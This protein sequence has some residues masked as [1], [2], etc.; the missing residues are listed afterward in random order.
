MTQIKSSN[1]AIIATAV[2]FGVSVA[3]AATSAQAQSN[4]QNAGQKIAAKGTVSQF[5]LPPKAP[6]AKPEPN[7]FEVKSVRPK[8]PR[9]A[10]RKI[11]VEANT[12][13]RT[14]RPRPQFSLPPETPQFADNSAVDTPI[15]E[16]APRPAPKVEKNVE[17]PAAPR[18]KQKADEQDLIEMRRAHALIRYK[19]YLKKYRALSRQHNAHYAA[20]KPAYGH[21]GKSYAH[22][23]YRTYSY[24]PRYVYKDYGHRSYRKYYRGHNYGYRRYNHGYRNY[25][26]SYRNHGYS[27]NRYNRHSYSRY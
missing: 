19:H 17:K 4:G 3:L 2:T 24:A 5:S 23:Q 27:Y 18:S 15:E 7:R 26:H 25:S 9:P 8:S 11:I 6:R 12:N 1:F 22:G 21:Y 10:N 20:K 13:P 16:K 14:E